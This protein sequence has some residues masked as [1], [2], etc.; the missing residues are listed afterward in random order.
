[1]EAFHYRYHP[2]TLRV[3]EIIASGELGKLKRVEATLCFPLPKFSDIRYNYS[4]AGGATM[5]AGCYAVH[6]A[7]TFGG[8][9]RK[10]FRRRRNCAIRRS[11]GP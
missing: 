11:T 2:L 3:E 5:D 10:S 4:L 9:P 7:R 6:M 1:M 8:S